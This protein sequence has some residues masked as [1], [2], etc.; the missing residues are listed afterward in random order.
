[1]PP[2]P[3]A[4]PP[5]IFGFVGVGSHEQNLRHQASPP[6]CQTDETRKETFS[7]GDKVVGDQCLTSSSDQGLINME[8]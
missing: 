7:L 8:L 5:R 6:G 1:M 3:V 4:K 2:E